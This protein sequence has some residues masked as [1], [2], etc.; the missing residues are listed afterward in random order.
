MSEKWEE[1]QRHEKEYIEKKEARVWQVPYSREYWR[2]FMH[3]T[4]TGKA[5]EV[6][7]GNNG[8]YNFDPDVTGLDPI[9]FNKPRF[10]RGMGED[11]HFPDKSFSYSLFCNGIDHSREPEKVIK[12]MLRVSNKAI[13]WV[14]GYPKWVAAVLSKI[15]KTHPYHFTKLE[16]RNLFGQYN[17]CFFDTYDPIRH[18]N[19][20]NSIIEK[21]KVFLM[22]IFGVVGYIYHIKEA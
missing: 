22:S 21:I 10:V 4:D 6:G 16:L 3:I 15:D 14:Y 5:L 17:I 2:N 12:E 11:L 9:Q 20:T 19:Y 18:I 8:L 13:F 7:C 1:A